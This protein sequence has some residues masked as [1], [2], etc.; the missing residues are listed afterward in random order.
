MGVSI[1]FHLATMNNYQEIFDEIY[2]EIVNSGLFEVI[3]NLNIC[4][5]GNGELQF[6]S[7][8]K[9][10][11][12][13]NN[14]ITVGE[15]FTLNILKKFADSLTENNN[16]LYLHTKGVTSPGNQCVVDW[17]KYMTYFNIIQYDKCIDSL[18]GY[19]T[20]GV[21]LVTEPTVHYSGTFW[22]ANSDYIKRLPK[23]DEIRYPKTPPILDIRHNGEFWIG[24]GN[25]NMTSLWNSNINVY[26]RHIHRYLR[27]E[28]EIK[29]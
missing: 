24:M 9:I 14:D 19:D 5:V 3:D 1:F 22:W 8:D 28:Y 2:S 23:I 20:C 21:D 27:D 13:K 26:E 15:F 4:I 18:K 16:I 17:R 25:G 29:S 11:I 12:Y 7:N 10:K 6:E